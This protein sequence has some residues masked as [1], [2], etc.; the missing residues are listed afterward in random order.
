M[1]APAPTGKGLP[2]GRLCQT[3]PELNLFRVKKLKAM[4]EGGC[5]LLE[6]NAV[7]TDV[8]P[9]YAHETD[10]VYQERKRRAYYENMFALTINQISA[11]LAQDPARFEA[12][13]EEKGQDG[14]DL[15][16]DQAMHLPPQAPQPKT[17]PTPPPSPFAKKD[18]VDS[19]D[20]PPGQKGPPIPPP[21]QPKIDP[22]TGEEIKPPTPDP[23]ITAKTI[24]PPPELDQYWKDLTD[25]ATALTD[26]G[27]GARGFDQILRDAAVEAL[28]TGW[29]WLQCDLPAPPD[30]DAEDDPYVPQ[31]LK[32]Q[33]DKGLLRAYVC[34][35]PT[36]KVYDWQE[37]NGKLLWV[38]TYECSVEALTPD[39]DRNAITHTW[40]D[41]TDKTWTKYVYV[42]EIKDG[43]PQPMP[44]PRQIIQAV[45][46]GDHSFKRVPW[47]RL[48]LCD[49][50][51]AHLHVG[52]MIESLCRNYFNRQ[53]G[54]SFQWSQYFYQQ[55]YEFLGP[56]IQGIDSTV[57]EAQ[58]DPSRAQR[59]RAPGMVHVRG[60]E[61]DARYV[62]PDMGG[63]QVGREATQD[64]RDAI[65]RITAQM[66]LAQDTSGA[67][68]RRSADSKRQDSVAQEIVLGAI[69]K[70]VIVFGKSTAKCLQVGR[71]EDVE[72]TP[73]LK[74][75]SRFNVMNSE[76]VINQAA[77][78]QTVKI[79]S[80]RLQIEIAYQCA[81]AWLGDNATPDMLAEI[82]MQLEKA[83]TQDQVMQVLK[84]MLMP[85]PPPL[86]LDKPSN[87]NADDGDDPDKEDKADEEKDKKPAP[88]FGGK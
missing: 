27:T 12:K 74:G 70:R 81:I 49:G 9:K 69:G 35:W 21:P 29:G 41:W 38:R 47:G 3:N 32:D 5:K 52:D 37:K 76:D 22:V 67:M 87:D 7:M 30:P 77:I 44:E 42:Q 25:N 28:V 33:E 58:Q 65:L 14:Y 20:G 71:G 78:L 80:A 51:G 82:R 72:E 39:A 10:A 54:E 6:N 45:A 56:E 57:S 88:P 36:D 48:N 85:P 11:G 43:I 46:E 50:G 53:N 4:Y 15:G 84:Q 62:A 79:P 73:D 34:Q 24:K 1:V 23:S 66:A 75:Y 59:K 2:Y 63:A 64:M 18:P 40:T 31:S 83:I 13:T 26:D 61:D 60:N 17:P 86:N 55:L 19:K 8:F 68:L 16:H